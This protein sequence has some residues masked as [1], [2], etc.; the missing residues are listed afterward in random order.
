MDKSAFW[1]DVGDHSAFGRGLPIGAELS[2]AGV[3]D[4]LSLSTQ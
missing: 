4:V 2:A 1:C 3:A